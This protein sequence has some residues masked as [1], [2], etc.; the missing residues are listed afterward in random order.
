MP[1]NIDEIKKLPSEEKL[2]TIDALWKSIDDDIAD[3]EL[4]SEET[5]LKERE[6]EYKAG[7]I[8]FDS[9]ENAEKRLREKKD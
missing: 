7:N 5:I 2:R 3:K 4:A 1:L 6:A 8:S 9:W